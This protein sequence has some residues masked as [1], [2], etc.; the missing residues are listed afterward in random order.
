MQL[1]ALPGGSGPRPMGRINPLI[2][3]GTI[4]Q[5]PHRPCL[6]STFDTVTELIIGTALGACEAGDVAFFSFSIPTAQ[7]CSILRAQ[8]ECEC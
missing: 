5:L 7:C 1:F 2:F 8:L 6:A 3:E 4:V